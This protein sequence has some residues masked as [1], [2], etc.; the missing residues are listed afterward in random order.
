[1][2]FSIHKN[3]KFQTNYDKKCKYKKNI[4]LTKQTIINDSFNFLN[5]HIM[6]F[7]RNRSIYSICYP[8][9]KQHI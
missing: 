5:I 9:K 8:R 3:M 7:V 2:F 6:L 4:H 1:M